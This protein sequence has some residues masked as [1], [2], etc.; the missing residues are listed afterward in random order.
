MGKIIVYNMD[1]RLNRHDKHAVIC[2]TAI[3]YSDE[4]LEH[5]KA[6]S[7]DGKYTIEDD[8]QPGPEAEPTYKERIDYLEEAL[9]LLLSG[10]TE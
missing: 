7:V 4:N 1:L 3:P 5:A 8:G 9:E 2:K 10:V 6:Y